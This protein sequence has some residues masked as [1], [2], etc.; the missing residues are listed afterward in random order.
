MAKTLT[1][2]L[3][4]NDL[5]PKESSG[6][7]KVLPCPFHK[8]DNEA[9]FTI[10][11]NETYFCFGCE[12]WGDAVK[13]LV[14]FKGI[15]PQEALEYVGIDYK[16]PKADK[17]QVIKVKNPSKTYKFLFDVTMDYHEFLMNTPGALNYLEKRGLSKETIVKYR[18]GY[19]DGNVLSLG[20]AFEM[21]MATEIGLVNKGGY[22]MMSHRITV[23][24]LTEEGYCDF[25]MGRTVTNDKIKYLGA[26][27]PKPIQGFF[28]VR[29][30]PILF[31]VEGQ[32]D[33]LTLRQWG[34]PAIAMSGTHSTK[35]N[36][37]LIA[38]KKLVAVPDYDES[39]VG[40][41]A[42]QRLVSKFGE[43]AMILDYSELRKPNEKLDISKLAEYP[44]GEYLFNTVV[45]EQLPWISYTSKRILSKWF[46]ALATTTPFP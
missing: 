19:T 38:G 16:T 28:E 12:V 20:T 27:M 34:Y 4:E 40:L 33:W 3:L 1:E 11:P 8:G 18:L 35:A 21:E 6:G 46:P 9:S 24:N 23:P 22:E 41:E 25:I 39:N 32:F 43:N 44:G 26:R 30:S 36:D 45:K 7:R 15:T 5:E 29:H 42:A 2:I 14:D 10:Y 13:F 17:A 31:V 37:Q